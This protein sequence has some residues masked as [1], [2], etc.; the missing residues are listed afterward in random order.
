MKEIR[1]VDVGE[2]ITEG[3]IKKWLVA[4]GSEVKEDQPLLQVETDKA[5]VNVPSPIDGTLKIAARENTTVK[6]GDTIAYI[7][8]K[9]ELESAVAGSSQ[10]ATRA[11]APQQPV[12]GQQARQQQRQ[13]SGA[14]SPGETLAAPYVRKLARDLDVEL[15]EIKGTGPG[16]RILENDVKSYVAASISGP[17]DRPAAMEDD[18]GRPVKIG[19]PIQA[20]AKPVPRFSET[21]E[22]QH[23]NDIERIPLSMTR[24]A[25]ARNMEASL[26]V[27]SAVHTDLIDAT[28]LWKIVTREKPRVAEELGVKLTFMPFIIKATI[29]ALM[30]SPNFNASY[31]R[32]RL[33]IIRKN[34]YNMGVAAEAPDGLKVFVIKYADKKSI[35]TIAK[36]MQNLAEKARNQTITLD[37]MRDST[38][39]ISNAGSLG[40]GFFTVPVINS[41]EVAILGISMIRDMAVV[42]DEMVR[43]AK[44]MPF[45][46]VFD[47]RVVDGAEAVRFGNTLKRYLE[48][49]VF[50]EMI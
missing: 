3:H 43:I 40:G 50:L 4:D 5:V 26:S 2:G 35:I 47:H 27:P 10:Q 25:I 12:Q 1:F 13:G 21:L 15:S 32:E 34:Y 20:G 8:T 49:P 44:I 48:N 16:G 29:A 41:P 30:E 7:G 9:P 37:E 23:K 19:A 24:K 14:Q 38:F 31:D 36:E 39:T 28:A 22:A 18:S 11:G 45:S 42:R 46:L 17:T 33:E 6:V